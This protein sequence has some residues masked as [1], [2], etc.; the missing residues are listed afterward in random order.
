MAKAVEKP[1]V[2]FVLSLAG[3]L[4]IICGS[5]F[6]LLFFAWFAEVAVI[7]EL[8]KPLPRQIILRFFDLYAL[9]LFPIGLISGAI[10]TIAAALLYEKPRM[11]VPLGALIVVFSVL[12]LHGS[13]GFSVGFILGLVGGILAIRWKP[14]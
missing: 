14:A 1:L 9:L 12:S 11:V 5:V 2:P 13:G 6:T 8:V 4:L 10:V 3:G 7:H